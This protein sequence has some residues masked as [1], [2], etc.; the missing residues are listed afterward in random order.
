M[1]WGGALELEGG[2]TWRHME[3]RPPPSDGDA[4]SYVG[5]WGGGEKLGG[6]G[7]KGG[8]EDPARG[9]RRGCVA[10]AMLPAPSRAIGGAGGGLCQMWDPRC[11]TEGSLPHNRPTPHNCPLY[12]T[13]APHT[14]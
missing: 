9:C 13:I 1:S 6:G 12:P 5:H 11:D 4:G 14:P 10:M 2:P 8:Q 3:N 7:G